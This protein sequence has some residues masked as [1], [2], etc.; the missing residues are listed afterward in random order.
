MNKKNKYTDFDYRLVIGGCGFIGSNLCESLC[1]KGLKVYSYD[2]YFTGTVEN[3]I[4]GVIYFKGDSAAINEQNFGVNFSHVYHLGEYSRVEQSFDDIDLVFEYNQNS[5]Y[6]VL[7]FDKENNS[8]IIYSGSSTKFGDDGI[9]P[10]ESPYAFT[11][12]SNVELVKAYCYWFNIEYAISYFYNVY[13]KREIGKGKYSTLIAK[14]IKLC[15][16]G[17]LTL[18]VTMPGTQRRNFTH[19]KDIV[20][21]LEL[22][23]THGLGDG[24][25]IA[26][27]ES[28]SINEI[29]KTLNKKPE[30]LPERK[31]NRM[32]API[33]VEKTKLLGWEQKHTLK[34]Y[35]RDML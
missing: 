22:I 21:A 8:K 11:K 16:E 30:Y 20:S 12:K 29:V 35:L 10:Y 17:N 34:N 3:H 1:Q 2:N 32:S 14:Y 26:A 18:P 23:G 6:S 15:E 19:I 13:G 4:D 25:G 5:I 27:Q 24:Y 28:Y 31:G 9:N 7:K 33:I